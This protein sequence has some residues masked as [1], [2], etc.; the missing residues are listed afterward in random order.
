LLRQKCVTQIGCPLNVSSH[1]LDD[2]W[3]RSQGLDTGIPWLFSHSICK[4][5]IFQT[6]ILSHPL[7]KLDDFK[8]IRRRS[9][10]LGQERV[11][12]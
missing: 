10:R 2:V 7:L 11:G 5:L 4:C 1:P 6:R 9:Q 12:V 8:R 3:S